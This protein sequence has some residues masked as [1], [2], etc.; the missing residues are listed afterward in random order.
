MKRHAV[1]RGPPGALAGTGRRLI[2]SGTGSGSMGSAQCSLNVSSAIVLI[3]ER[4]PGMA[5]KR[6]RSNF[7]DCVND[8][9]NSYRGDALLGISCT[10][11]QAAVAA[12]HIVVYDTVL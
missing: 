12:R 3:V 2:F 7:P 4:T 5:P 8:F 6:S 1:P 9:G 11:V 10:R